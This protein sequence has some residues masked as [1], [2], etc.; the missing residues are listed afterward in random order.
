MCVREIERSLL[1]SK[2]SLKC[3]LLVVG[4]YEPVDSLVCPA[5]TEDQGSWRSTEVL[6]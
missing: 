4:V 5:R 3:N 1:L 6:V 2:A